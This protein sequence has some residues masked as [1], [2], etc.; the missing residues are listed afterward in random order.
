MHIARQSHQV[1]PTMERA[2]RADRGDARATYSRQTNPSSTARNSP[3]RATDGCRHGS[4]SSKSV[5]GG[6]LVRAGRAITCSYRSR[7]DDAPGGGGAEMLT[8][9]A[10][11]ALNPMHFPFNRHLDPHG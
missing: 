1:A 10:L 4:D 5:N 2:L 6:S 8:D 7:H 3:A 9:A 11:K